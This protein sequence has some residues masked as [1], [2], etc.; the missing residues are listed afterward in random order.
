MPHTGQVRV[1]P[2]AAKPCMPSGG[3]GSSKG[4]KQDGDLRQSH[5]GSLTISRLAKMTLWL[6]LP[7]STGLGRPLVLS[8][9]LLN[10]PVSVHR[11][12]VRR[13]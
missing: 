8:E 11:E 1:W 2:E 12:R 6:K 5:K 7:E 10:Q 9:A 3:T 13:H 4:D